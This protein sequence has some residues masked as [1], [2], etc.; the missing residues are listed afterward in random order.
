M[1]RVLKW[2]GGLVSALVLLLAALLLWGMGPGN[3]GRMILG[4][5]IV[6]DADAPKLPD[7]NAPTILIF[8]K[9]NG[10]RDSAQI[11]AAN[12]ALEKLAK[13]KGWST[14]TTQNA[15]VFNGAQLSQFRAVVWN[16]VSGD[17]LTVGQRAAFRTWLESGGGYVGL[18]GAGGDPSYKWRW[19]AD[20]LIGAQFI[21]H[22]LSPH[23]QRGR[24]IVE[25]HTHPATRGLGA[26][27]IRN[28]E[29]YSFDKSPRAKGYLILVTLDETS[30]AP[31]LRFPLVIDKDISMGKDHPMVWA[32]CV[33]NGSAFYS[34]LGHQ[35]GAYSESRHLAMISGAISWAAGFEGPKCAGGREILRSNG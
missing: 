20:E 21:G 5:G 27:W 30:Y 29:W 22:T 6:Y 18:H 4:V 24:L 33:R 34:A 3:I 35:A 25:D 11:D 32:H 8:S 19:Y 9:T 17:V 12:S 2:G 28:D 10:F 7:F 14:Y 1:R 15:A 31:R 16:S 26:E 23:I 13:D